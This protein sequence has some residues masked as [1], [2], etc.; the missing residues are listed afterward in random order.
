MSVP[1]SLMVTCWERKAVGLCLGCL[2]CL[3]FVLSLSH[4]VSWVGDGTL[5][6]G[7][8]IFAFFFHFLIRA[9][10]H[11]MLDLGLHCF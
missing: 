1:C 3:S 9:G 7:F 10:I 6:Y 2:L 11:K 8:L 4:M 5:L